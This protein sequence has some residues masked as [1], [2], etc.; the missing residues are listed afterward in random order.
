MQISETNGG[1]MELALGGDVAAI[2]RCM[3]NEIGSAKILYCPDDPARIAA[4]NFTSDLKG[5]ISYFVTVDASAHFPQMILSGDNNL[6]IGSI[7]VR[8]GLL[9]V[10]SNTPIAWTSARHKYHGNLG[11]ADGSVEQVTQ[12]GLLQEI[13]L[14]SLATNFP[15]VRLAIP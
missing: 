6:E 12:S 14:T 7:P 15:T 4:T 1:A 13:Q 8:P 2:F 11:I 3:S 9:E 5:K 10:F